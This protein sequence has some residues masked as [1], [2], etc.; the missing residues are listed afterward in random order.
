MAKYELLPC[1]FCGGRAKLEEKYR[2]FI[3]GKSERVALVRCLACGARAGR[4]RISD[5]GNTSHSVEATED[6][7][8]YWNNRSVPQN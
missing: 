5:Y 8:R 4:A 3:A 1:P 7:V 6:A 2:S